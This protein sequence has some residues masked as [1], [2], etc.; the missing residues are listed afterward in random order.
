MNREG[1]PSAKNAGFGD[2]G[3]ILTRAARRVVQNIALHE[4]G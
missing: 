3:V 4:A 1:F 2:E